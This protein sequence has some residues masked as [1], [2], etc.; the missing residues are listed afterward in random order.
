MRICVC[1]L[2]PYSYGH[3]IRATGSRYPDIPTRQPFLPSSRIPQR[4]RAEPPGALQ[5]PDFFDAST[6]NMHVE[7]NGIHLWNLRVHLV[8]G[9]KHPVFQNFP[10]KT[11]DL[12][13]SGT[14]PL[15]GNLPRPHTKQNSPMCIPTGS[16]TY[17]PLPQGY[18][19]RPSRGRP[20][21]MKPGKI[22]ILAGQFSTV[23]NEEMN[24][25]HKHV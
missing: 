7:I 1:K 13:H 10:N 19:Q 9:S 18:R 14:V 4:L 23:R 21:A 24:P 3:S 16:F 15:P 6:D 25:R 2:D 12:A 8:Q 5:G 11:G 17:A 22:Y 20:S